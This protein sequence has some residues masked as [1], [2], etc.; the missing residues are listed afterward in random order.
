MVMKH[1]KNKKI[2]IAGPCAAESK[3]QIAITIREAKKRDIDFVRVNLWKPRTKPG[4]DGL[5]SYGLHLLQDVAR[6]GLNPGLE[7]ILPEQVKLAMDAVL[8]ITKEG[9]LLVWIGARNQNHVIQ[10]EIAQMAA[11]NP[12]VFLMVK[13]QPWVSEEHWIG[14]VEHVLAGGIQKENILLCHRGFAPT[15]DNPQSLRNMPDFAMS[16]RV[17]EHLNLPMI[18]DPSHIGGTVPNVMQ[19]TRES[20]AYNFDGLVVE[21][22]PNPQVAKTDSKQQVT[23]EQFDLLY[24]GGSL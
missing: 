6:A 8:P 1:T 9:K 14:I 2:L 18:F 11:K 12:R 10:Q 4:F 16:M 19:V 5:G 22:H 21:V 15:G 13:N 24:K 3:E 20:E 23:W 7:V 17:K